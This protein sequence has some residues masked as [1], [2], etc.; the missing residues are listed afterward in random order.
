MRTYKQEVSKLKQGTISLLAW[1]L[2]NQKE[3]IL[4]EWDNARNGGV[5][6]NDISY[7]SNKQVHWTCSEGHF[8]TASPW[9][10]TQD[11]GCPICTGKKIM[12]GYNDLE[13][14]FPLL[15]KEWHPT[16]NG[17]LTPD[18]VFP[19]SNKM[20]WWI[21]EF[22]H[23]WK[24]TINSRHKNRCPHCYQD[25]RISVREKLVYFNLKKYFP[26]TLENFK[27]SSSSKI[28]V[29]MCIPSLKLVVEYDG[30]LF[31]QDAQRDTNRFKIIEDEGYD[32]I[33]IREPNLPLLD[34]G[35][36][37][38]LESTSLADVASGIQKLF[39][40][41]NLEYNIS[42]PFTKVDVDADLP[43]VY[44]LIDFSVVDNS[45][46]SIYP[47]LAKEFHPTLNGSLNPNRITCRSG[48]KVFWICPDDHSY[49]ATVL[50]RTN[51]KG[52]PYCAGKKVLAGYNDL[53]TLRPEIA[54]QWDYEKNILSPEEVTAYSHKKV[55]WKCRHG[56]SWEAPVFTRKTDGCSCSSKKRLKRPNQETSL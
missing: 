46:E 35:H 54:Q 24:A 6:P 3:Y 40:K 21:C 28:T 12:K 51:G 19:F 50:N 20:A 2:K 56:K 4:E 25:H 14:Q 45:L 15:A 41:L 11:M 42:I 47:E 44:K 26:E 29:D 32:L 43:E 10:R 36:S 1:C 23:E 13:S 48:L 33:R 34:H 17:H 52:C 9:A 39:E 18:Q 53:A 16:K 55:W 27:L 38:I 5:T 37:I 8:Y 31:H 22:G 30:T 49:Q 7:G